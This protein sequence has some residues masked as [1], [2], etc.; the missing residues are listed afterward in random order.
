MLRVDTLTAKLVMITLRG[1]TLAAKLV[2]T[3]SKLVNTSWDEI[4]LTAKL[5]MD[6]FLTA[7]LVNILLRVSMTAKLVNIFRDEIYRK[8]PKRYDAIRNTNECMCV[9]ALF[10]F[11]FCFCF[12]IVHVNLKYS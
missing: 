1:D 2:N 7:T 4:D 3:S 12:F 6:Y 8:N 10:W 9:Y 11:S 5:N